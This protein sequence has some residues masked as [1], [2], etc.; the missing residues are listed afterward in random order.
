MTFSEYAVA[1]GLDS[2]TTKQSLSTM[3]NLW[4]KEMDDFP[5]E[6]SSFKNTI[7]LMLY[8]KSQSF[9]GEFTSGG[10]TDELD[11]YVPFID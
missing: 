11:T 10:W 4:N 6:V 2:D 9:P 1:L 8:S 3:T 5:D 7:A